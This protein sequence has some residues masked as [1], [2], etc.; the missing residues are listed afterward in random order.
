MNVKP[1]RCRSAQEKPKGVQGSSALDAEGNRANAHRPCLDSKDE[2]IGWLDGGERASI[3][4]TT[5]GK[6]DW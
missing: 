4:R 1:D 2:N 6:K 3:Q 5:W